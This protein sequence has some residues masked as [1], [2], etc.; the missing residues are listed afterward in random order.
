LNK[1]ILF[2][3]FFNQK[4]VGYSKI[5]PNEKIALFLLTFFIA[6]TVFAHEYIFIA[7]N[8]VVKQGE[9]L[10][11]HLFVSDGFNIEAERPFKKSIIKNFELISEK[12]KTDLLNSAVE[13]KFPILE[14]DIDFKGLGLIHMS[15]DYAQITMQND[16]FKDYLRVDNIENITIDTTKKQQTERYTRYLKT[17]IQSDRKEN[18]SIYKMV[19]L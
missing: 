11:L 14:M 2:T 18:D 4:K 3:F 5:N 9:K 6:T 10:E 7:Y 16:K 13:G 17:L 15:R 19:V 8:Y 1:S 12:G